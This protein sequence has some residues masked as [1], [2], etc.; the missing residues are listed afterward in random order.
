MD[1][2]DRG[3]IKLFCFFFNDT[4][5]TEIYTL[6]LHDALPIYITIAGE[7]SYPTTGNYFDPFTAER[8]YFKTAGSYTFRLEAKQNFATT[9]TTRI[10]F[11]RVVATFFPTSYGS[12]SAFV[13]S[14]EASSFEN[15]ASVTSRSEERRVGKE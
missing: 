12:V 8:V 1:R 15:A 3:S 13:S 4:A 14:S 6:S 10:V 5:T 7:S 9:G 2:C 11:P